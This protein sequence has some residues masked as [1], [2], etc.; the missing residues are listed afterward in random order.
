MPSSDPRH[1]N[2]PSMRTRSSLVLSAPQALGSAC[3]CAQE[4]SPRT[5]CPLAEPTPAEP[6]GVP[7]RCRSGPS[8]SAVR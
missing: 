2:C 4:A 8:G 1:G 5:V 3:E 6:R 7:P